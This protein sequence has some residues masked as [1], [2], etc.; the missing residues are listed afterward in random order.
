MGMRYS[1]EEET[2]GRREESREQKELVEE[3]GPVL[4]G[5]RARRRQLNSCRMRH[6]WRGHPK[7]RASGWGA[8]R[9]AGIGTP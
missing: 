6:P 4:W 7:T 2:S 8:A 9:A 5:Q 1:G 3:Q